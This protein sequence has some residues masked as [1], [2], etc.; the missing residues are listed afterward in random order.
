MTSREDDFSGL[1]FRRYFS[2]I[3][4]AEIVYKFLIIRYLCDFISIAR[5]VYT[6]ELLK[7]NLKFCPLLG[8]MWDK[9]GLERVEYLDYQARILSSFPFLMERFFCAPHYLL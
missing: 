9:K 3:S 4:Y 8:A 6:Y 5:R 7:E 2:T 1:T